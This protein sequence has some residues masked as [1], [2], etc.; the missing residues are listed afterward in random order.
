MEPFGVLNL[1][2]SLLETNQ[3]TEEA[4]P[5]S[6]EKADPADPTPEEPLQAQ[7]QN[8]YLRFAEAHEERAR[9]LRK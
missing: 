8:S 3:K 9:K 1:I 6:T 2:R 5:P 7:A 4:P